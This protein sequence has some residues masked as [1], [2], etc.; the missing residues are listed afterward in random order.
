MSVEHTLCI[1][2]MGK[3]GPREGINDL[4][5]VTWQ[6]RGRI[7]TPWILSQCSCGSIKAFE[8]C[9]FCVSSHLP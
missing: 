1:L 2:Q 9:R 7:P 4:V 8:N 5:K 3:P 6:E